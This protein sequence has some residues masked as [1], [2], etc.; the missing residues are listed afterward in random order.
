MKTLHWITLCLWVGSACCLAGERAGQEGLPPSAEG[1]YRGPE[2][3]W[4]PIA[5]D[6]KKA[7]DAIDGEIDFENIDV[8][9]V[10]RP[11]E[12]ESDAGW[13]FQYR[14]DMWVHGYVQR[15]ARHTYKLVFAVEPV[16]RDRELQELSPRDEVRY[17]LCMKVAEM[18]N[19]RPGVAGFTKEKSLAQVADE[20]TAPVYSLVL[21]EHKKIVLNR[22][23]RDD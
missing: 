4:K 21:N 3:E 7:A 13:M 17:S 2:H 22:S 1:W 19:P 14:P 8:Q 6:L 11:G 12:R 15:R 20:E 9:C 16:D 5:R 18:E 10:E 23:L